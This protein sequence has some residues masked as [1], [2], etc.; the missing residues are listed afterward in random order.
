MASG[1]G[2]VSV[3]FTPPELSSTEIFGP[4]PVAAAEKTA[5][6]TGGVGG[7]EVEATRVPQ[8]AQKTSEPGVTGVPHD[9][10]TARESAGEGET[11]ATRPPHL[12]QNGSEGSTA[13]PQLGQGAFPGG[14][15]ESG[16][17]AGPGRAAATGGA[18]G[19]ELGGDAAPGAD[20][21]ALGEPG[22]LAEIRVG[23]TP[24]FS[25]LGSV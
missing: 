23:G 6:P 15:D 1:P 10:Q 18:I 4:T 3:F 2:S 13:V 20:G 21:G 11:R 17:I 9:P 5:V 24:N 19:G 12:G 16:G 14:I 8:R 22:T 7:E 25:L